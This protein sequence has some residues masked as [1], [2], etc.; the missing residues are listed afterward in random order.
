MTSGA[1]AL[2]DSEIFVLKT[3]K[4]YIVRPAHLAARRG[5]EI[6][7][8]NYTRGPAAV[9]LPKFQQ[10]VIPIAAGE[11]ASFRVP[12]DAASGAHAYAVYSEEASDFC[13]GESSPIVIIRD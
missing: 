12:D 10:R 13:V 9:F 5:D 3:G 4:G 8:Y 6:R 1:K 7:V 11:S 2:D